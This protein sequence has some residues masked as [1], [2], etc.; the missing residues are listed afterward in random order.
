MALVDP[1]RRSA[2]V[3]AAAQ[4]GFSGL[5]RTADLLFS[6]PAG[7]CLCLPSCGSV[8]AGGGADALFQSNL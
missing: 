8:N 2:V 4:R 5:E 7:S 6:T 1:T 3:L